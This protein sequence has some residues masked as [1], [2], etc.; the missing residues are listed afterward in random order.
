[1]VRPRRLDDELLQRGV[2][3]VRE[4]EQLHVGHVPEHRLHEREHAHHRH[5]DEQRAARQ[6]REPRE[7]DLAR[8]LAGV[9]PD[10]DREGDADEADA[11]PRAE[12][13]RAIA[14]PGDEP[15]RGR[16]RERRV[17][18]VRHRLP[19]EEAGPE[20]GGDREEQRGLG[21]HHLP[22]DHRPGR[23]RDQVL[24]RRRREGR[25]PLLEGV[26][27][28]EPD[29]AERVG[30]DEDDREQDRVAA[31]RPEPRH[32]AAREPPEERDE[33]RHERAGPGADAPEV[34]ALPLRAHALE[35]DEVARLDPL[36]VADDLLAPLHRDRHRLHAGDGVGAAVAR[37][38]LVVH[39]RRPE[40][41]EREPLD[42]GAHGG[43]LAIE[44]HARRRG[45]LP[46]RALEAAH[47]REVGQ[48]ALALQLALAQGPDDDSPLAIRGE[49]RLV[50]DDHPGEPLLHEAREVALHRLGEAGAR[51][52]GEVLVAHDELQAR[53]ERVAPGR[54]P[55][56]RVAVPSRAPG[57]ERSLLLAHEVEGGV[58]PG[59]RVRGRPGVVLEDRALGLGRLG[60]PAGGRRLVHD[61]VV[62]I[63]LDG[64]WRGRPEGLRARQA[65][66]GRRD[67]QDGCGRRGRRDERDA[68][69]L[70]GPVAAR[71]AR[72]E[73]A[74]CG[75]MWDFGSRHGRGSLSPGPGERNGERGSLRNPPA[76]QVVAA[77]RGGGGQ[78]ERGA[79]SSAG[80]GRPD[81]AASR[82][83]FAASARAR[84]SASYPS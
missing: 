36:P 23:E 28:G 57:R 39:E 77:R 46:A 44:P 56:R 54:V 69:E 4:L 84:R 14:A 22:D 19:V 8:A 65:A 74:R 20:P 71:E 60:A 16:R 53:D 49:E 7:R 27:D 13:P 18:R 25:E 37:L 1:M 5:G 30:A 41:G 15:R 2:V 45:D 50:L 10:R 34:L 33:E 82:S 55:R 81:R 75:Q 63:R 67:E 80:A 64:R 61:V 6:R 48:D 66:R 21:G 76:R 51:E 58:D 62:A 72:E 52:R 68:Q 3:Q 24:Q 79:S 31:R 40:H 17:E 12:E 73:A 43:G 32:V 83:A 26:G 11:E 35:D 59:G 38:H 78:S 42:R 9:K 47:P 29:E 70:A